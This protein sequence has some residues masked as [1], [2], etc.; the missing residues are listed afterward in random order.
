M[1]HVSSVS[2]HLADRTQLIQR[3][4]M[5]GLVAQRLPCYPSRYRVIAGTHE[6]CR[7]NP[8]P[9]YAPRTHVARRLVP[10]IERGM[11]HELA[12]ECRRVDKARLQLNIIFP[13]TLQ[14]TAPYLAISGAPLEGTRR[15]RR[16][17][18]QS[19]PLQ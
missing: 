6:Q 11:C 1:S 12:G 16:V 18:A 15:Q 10:R 13:A 14:A 8:P 4:S 19:R 5:E 9:D 2:G 3:E 17:V 7:I